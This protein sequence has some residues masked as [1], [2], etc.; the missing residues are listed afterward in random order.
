MTHRL[1]WSGRL[2]IGFLRRRWRGGASWL[3]PMLRTAIVPSGVRIWPFTWTPSR[4][5]LIGQEPIGSN[6]VDDLTDRSAP[7]LVAPDV[8]RPSS[9]AH[10]WAD[11]AVVTHLTL[12][13]NRLTD[14]RNPH[15]AHRYETRSNWVA[16]RRSSW[17]S[18]QQ[19]KRVMWS[20]APQECSL[21]MHLRKT[22]ASGAHRPKAAAWRRSR[23]LGRGPRRQ[24][25]TPS[26]R[27]NMAYHTMDLRCHRPKT[28]DRA[29][30]GAPRCAQQPVC[31]V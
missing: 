25:G 8:R 5:G 22:T 26:R 2:P 1:P 16:S 28:V 4:R 10:A 30:R 14:H 6:L 17:P 13:S 20:S 27:R 23:R 24:S 29:A 19:R 15:M 31:G 9:N 18:S 21:A 3:H 12:T 11:S 7:R